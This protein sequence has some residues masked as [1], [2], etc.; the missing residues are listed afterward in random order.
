MNVAED[1]PRIGGTAGPLPRTQC[2]SNT[3]ADRGSCNSEKEAPHQ[4]MQEPNKTNQNSG[5]PSKYIKADQLRIL[6][7][8]S[9]T[10]QF[11]QRSGLPSA[12][13]LQMFLKINFLVETFIKVPIILNSFI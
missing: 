5:A 13:I 8:A 9:T 2:I 7:P 1:V 3:Q 4:F 6:F 12:H 11:S 10:R